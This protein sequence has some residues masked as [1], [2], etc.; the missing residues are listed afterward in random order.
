MQLRKHIYRGKSV[1]PILSLY[2]VSIGSNSYTTKIR[3]TQW[4]WELISAITRKPHVCVIWYFL[5][6]G[7]LHCVA[8]YLTYTNVVISTVL[9]TVGLIKSSSILKGYG[10]HVA[11][12]KSK[13]LTVTCVDT[14]KDMVANWLCNEAF[15]VVSVFKYR[16]TGVH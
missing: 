16:E 5:S 1:I 13:C 6:C 2:I 8:C 3:R 15:E 4:T 9:A 12:W 7:A 10:N 11:L 14:G